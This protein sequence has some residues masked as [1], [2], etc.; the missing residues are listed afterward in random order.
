VL[1]AVSGFAVSQRLV[2]DDDHWQ[3]HASSL[4]PQAELFLDCIEHVESA[5]GGSRNADSLQPQIP[6]SEDASPVDDGAINITRCKFRKAFRKADHGDVRANG[7]ML[8]TIG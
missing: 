1:A 6:G 8:A 5:G 7:P 4:E 2:V 3:G